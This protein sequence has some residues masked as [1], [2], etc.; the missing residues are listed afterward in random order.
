M[1]ERL[2]D[3][4]IFSGAAGG[5]SE[6]DVLMVGRGDQDDVDVFAREEVAVVRSGI[7]G[8]PGDLASLVEIV[9]PNVTDRG[10]ANFANGFDVAHQCLRASAGADATD[11]DGVVGSGDAG[12]GE[13]AK[14]KLTSIH[15]F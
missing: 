10:D 12:G 6:R 11:A 13:R 14:Q 9:L 5:D 15:W 8:R 3:V 4:D 1:G 2:L 7:S